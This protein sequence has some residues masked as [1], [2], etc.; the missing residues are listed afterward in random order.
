MALTLAG[1]TALSVYA[2]SLEELSQ[3]K[4]EYVQNG[5]KLFSQHCTVC[6]GEGGKGDGIGGKALNPPPRDLTHMKGWKFGN[7]LPRMFKTL[8]DGIPTSGMPGFDYL[9]GKDRLMILHFVRSLNKGYP[10]IT[11]AQM[12][13]LNAQYKL[14]EAADAQKVISIEDAIRILATDSDLNS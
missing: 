6:H 1:L 2:D 4:S 9:S 5:K 10:K 7:S 14:T 11:M 13:Q 3:P 8:H 12:K